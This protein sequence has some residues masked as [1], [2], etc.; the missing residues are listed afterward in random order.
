MSTVYMSVYVCKR[1]GVI[2]TVGGG[3]WISFLICDHLAPPGSC[4]LEPSRPACSASIPH[5]IYGEV[6]TA[7]GD[8]L[9]PN[10][11]KQLV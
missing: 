3:A 9:S 5:G 4:W 10:T 6:T 11:L 2:T 7:A 1:G 8:T